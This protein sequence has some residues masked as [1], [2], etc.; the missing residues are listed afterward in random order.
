MNNY[1]VQI[2]FQREVPLITT[3]K[4]QDGLSFKLDFK[5]LV[6][7]YLHK[8]FSRGANH[9]QL[10]PVSILTPPFLSI[11]IIVCFSLLELT[12]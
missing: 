12:I 11:E 9:I 7:S 1:D 6:G 8:L 4:Q 5:L 10:I 3:T 2:L